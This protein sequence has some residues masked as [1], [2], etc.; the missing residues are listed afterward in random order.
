MGRYWSPPRGK[1]PNKG[2]ISLPGG[3]IILGANP[4]TVTYLDPPWGIYTATTAITI[5]G[6]GFYDAPTITA[7]GS[8]CTSVSRVDSQTIT[9][10]VPTAPGGTKNQAGDVVLTFPS[11][12]VV[13]ITNGFKWITD[14]TA[15]SPVAYLNTDTTAWAG[16]SPWNSESPGTYNFTQ[17][18]GS[19]VPSVGKT[20]SRCINNSRPK[21]AALSDSADYM[22]GSANMSALMSASPDFFYSGAALMYMPSNAPDTPALIYQS[23]AILGGNST[24]Y[25]GI[26]FTSEPKV[27]LYHWQ[28]SPSAAKYASRSVTA[29]QWNIITWRYNGSNVQVGVNEIP[30]SGDA[31]TAIHTSARSQPLRVF[32]QAASG[33][34][35]IANLAAMSLYASSLTDA[36]FTDIIYAYQARYGV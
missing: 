23:D 4:P 16:A 27:Y 31:A 25:F 18:T 13:T 1:L 11:G 6:Q 21:A 3:R 34:S 26:H 24:A 33:N 7:G 14:I 19:S 22:T 28:N 35:I 17:G 10:T 5:Y 29:G 12:E 30:V 8:S 20:T 36:N 2:R 9:C 15:L 32:H